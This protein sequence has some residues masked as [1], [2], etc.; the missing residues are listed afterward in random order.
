LYS[1]FARRFSGCGGNLTAETLRTAETAMLFSVDSAVL[2]ASAVN[3]VA[4]RMDSSNLLKVAQKIA[5]QWFVNLQK[6]AVKR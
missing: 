5:N 3:P 2:G 1:G 6:S 4:I